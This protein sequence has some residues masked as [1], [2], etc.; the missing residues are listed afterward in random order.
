[1]AGYSLDEVYGADSK[2]ASLDDVYGKDTTPKNAR[3]WA[4]WYVSN[5][6]RGGLFGIG[7]GLMN[8]GT[9]AWDRAAY[10]V[11][12]FVTDKASKIMPAGEGPAAA[13]Y[14]ANIAT[15]YIPSL[16]TSQAAMAASEKPM[17]HLS[18]WLYQSALRPPP[19]ALDRGDAAKAIDTMLREGLNPSQGG[20]NKLRAQISKLNEE[21]QAAIANSPATVDRNRAAA[22]ANDAIKKFEAQVNPGADVKK[23][24]DAWTEFLQT[25]PKDI[26]VQL[27][28]KIKQGTYGILGS[29]AYGEVGTAETEAQKAIARGLKDEI[30]AVV[31]SVAPKN[32]RESELIN[33][34]EL[35]QHRVN[36]SAN[37]NPVPGLTLLSNN[38][39]QALGWFANSSDMVK[40]WLARAIYSNART[41]PL[42]AGATAGMPLGMTS[43]ASPEQP[44]LT[45][46]NSRLMGVLSSA[47][48]DALGG[49]DSPVFDMEALRRVKTLLGY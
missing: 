29:K 30:A 36:M 33:A 41:A 19:S 18:R 37:T 3:E 44:I 47:Y 35:A 15:Q 34:A 22:Y 25:F 12:G 21:I 7:Q 46:P 24:A 23:I 4:A 6:L 8:E 31:P 2:S 39:T 13:G 32:A 38:P 40:S 27:A 28:Q 16:L 49:A 9:K 48:K 42:V 10:D 45:D 20:V 17:Q 5:L 11:G 43:G 14:A 26:P 1:M